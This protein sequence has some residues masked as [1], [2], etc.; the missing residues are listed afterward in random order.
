MGAILQDCDALV[1]TMD[2]LSGPDDFYISVNRKIYES[3]LKLF[4]NCEPFDILSLSE[5]LRS[6]GW[7]SEVGGVEY[8]GELINSVPTSANVRVHARVVREKAALRQLISKAESV[9]TTAYEQEGKMD[10]VV[11]ELERMIMDY[12]QKRCCRAF[13]KVG[14]IMRDRMKIVD[15]MYKDKRLVTGVTTGY[16]NL[17]EKTGG[18]QKSNL[19]IVAGP[20]SMG[21]TTFVMNIVQ[22]F[23]KEV[24]EAVVCVFSLDMSAE[25][26][27]LF[28]LCSESR[29]ML[30]KV[31]SGY[32]TKSDLTKL[33]R[34]AELMYKQQVYI[35]D[36]PAM[37]VINIRGKAHRLQEEKGRLDLIVVDYLQLI[38]SCGKFESRAQELSWI[39]RSLKQLA[40]E[41]DVP[42]LLICQLSHKVECREGGH[43]RPQLYDLPEFEAIEPNADVVLFVHREEFY[44]RDKPE[45]WNKME[46]IIGKQ[47]NGPLGSIQLN[48]VSDCRLIS[49][50]VNYEED[51]E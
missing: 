21:K 33:T 31:K 30:Q 32:L 1:K 22:N 12:S 20:P 14:D 27:T 2:T 24:K 23:I 7:L 40:K 10:T 26:M 15:N 36:T 45:T 6:K 43:R 50:Y 35:D 11:D 37:M 13:Q 39:T 8:M 41:L 19:I 48:Y 4:D 49:D 28:L 9:L 34:A 38:D 29:V 17:D 51:F 25:Q 18:L 44:T 47:R 16:R 42:V 3:I 46:I 5:A